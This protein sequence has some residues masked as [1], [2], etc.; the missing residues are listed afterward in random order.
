[1][2]KPHHDHSD[3]RLFAHPEMVRDLLTGFVPQPWVA[4]ADLRTLEPVK[5][6][7]VT[8]DFRER[9]DDMIWRVRL[10]DD[11][12]YVYLL[13]EFQSG[14]D[15]FMA[16]RIAA[17]VALLYQDLIEQKRLTPS[18]LPPPVLPVVLYNGEARW[19][20]PCELDALITPG[21]GGL[22]DWRPRVRDLLL[23]QGAIVHDPAWTPPL[24]NLAA[25][26][27]QLEHA[28]DEAT[29]LGLYQSLRAVLDSGDLASLK[30]A[31]GRW[32][33]KSYIRKKRPGIPL[34]DINDYHEV[35]AVL[36]ERVEQ[37]NRQ[38]IEQGR[39]E[40]RQEGL[41]EGR[42]EGRREAAVALLTRQLRRR[43]GPLPDWADARLAAASA[44][45]LEL[46]T[47][48]VLT[49]DTLEAVFSPP[50]AGSRL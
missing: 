12:L 14:I 11:W 5:G 48:A 31:F 15:P 50:A 25:A 4:L 38:L 24:K 17:Y 16:V 21:P 19:Q 8:D 13:L 10:G 46:L 43:F 35:H 26:L 45:E 1:M 37:W 22:A 33:Y 32:I 29:W 40:G 20:A 7:F 39:Q 9:E 27:F 49:A 2:P 23:D 36:Q 47:D 30:R 28:R 41:Q 34:P 3:K 44:E 18:G 42:Q 6:S